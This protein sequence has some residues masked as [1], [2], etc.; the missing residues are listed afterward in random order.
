MTTQ[1]YPETPQ[2]ENPYPDENYD[3]GLLDTSGYGQGAS[4]PA[5][6]LFL[7]SL[8]VTNDLS[9]TG[10]QYVTQTLNAQG[11]IIGLANQQLSG[12]LAVGGPGSFGGV[13]SA[14]GF[15]YG[16]RSFFGANQFVVE[17]PATFLNSLTTSGAAQFQQLA[18]NAVSSSSVAA[19][20]LSVAPSFTNP[21]SAFG[22]PGDYY[23]PYYQ[24]TDSDGN[25][26]QTPIEF[27][28]CILSELPQDAVVLAYLPNQ[29]FN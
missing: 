26:I 2:P 6:P 25:P 27:V 13:V 9:V 8:A 18:A 4:N 17:D 23:S 12:N 5:P 14:A 15:T 10:S 20:V 21:R 1:Y 16:G 11:N 29:N 3:P 28:P 19:Q 24:P 7:E 22:L